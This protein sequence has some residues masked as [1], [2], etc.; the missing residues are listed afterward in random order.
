[1]SRSVSACS[2][3][4]SSERLNGTEAEDETSQAVVEAQEELREDDETEEAQA[5]E[6]VQ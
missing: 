5:E 6:K 3:L 1:M 2:A 4:L